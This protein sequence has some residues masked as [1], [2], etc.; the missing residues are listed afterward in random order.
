MLQAVSSSVSTQGLATACHGRDQRQL[1][2]ARSVGHGRG[3]CRVACSFWCNIHRG[4]LWPAESNSAGCCQDTA[5]G[6][7]RL[8]LLELLAQHVHVASKL[9][10]SSLQV[11]R[12]S[13]TVY[14]YHGIMCGQYSRSCSGVMCFSRQ[15][16]SRGSALI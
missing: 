8:M 14:V 2:A 1:P 7:G 11:G 5:Y 3:R 15:Q 16:S 13:L 10:L 12:L 9:S 6:P 4:K